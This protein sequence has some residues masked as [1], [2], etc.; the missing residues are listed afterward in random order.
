MQ[1]TVEIEIDLPRERVIELFD[2]VDNVPKWQAGLIKYEPTEGEP[3]QVGSKAQ[4]AFELG[5][6]AIEVTETITDRNL[7]EEFNFTYEANDVKNVVTNRFIDVAPDQTK[8]ISECSF[9]FSGM[10]K[11]IGGT[12]KT[13]FEKRSQKALEDFKAFAETGRDVRTA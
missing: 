1:Y 12:M 2:S 11:I 8:W 5:G 10:M 3:G 4:L 6:G 7:P 13:T 9:T